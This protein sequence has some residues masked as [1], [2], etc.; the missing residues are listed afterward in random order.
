MT[1]EKSPKGRKGGN[2]ETDK[3]K[4]SYTIYASGPEDAIDIKNQILINT[5]DKELVNM[6]IYVNRAYI[7]S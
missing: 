4:I 1:E 3:H 2:M 6:D 5:T 7:T